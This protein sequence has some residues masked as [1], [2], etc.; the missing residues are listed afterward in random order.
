M[1]QTKAMT[2]H[3]RLRTYQSM[4]LLLQV[5]IGS[6]RSCVAVLKSTVRKQKCKRLHC[7]GCQVSISPSVCTQVFHSIA[8]GNFLFLFVLKSET[9][10]VTATVTTSCLSIKTLLQHIA[11]Q[12]FTC[13]TCPSS[14]PG[15]LWSGSALLPCND[16]CRQTPPPWPPSCGWR[17][18]G[19][20]AGPHFAAGGFWEKDKRSKV[21]GELNNTSE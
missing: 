15:H 3:H 1:R 16:G 12:V 19:G 10:R 21:T 4:K 6:L 8:S 14:C 13:G 17:E 7:R 2:S 11:S 20:A 5:L 9:G 18:R